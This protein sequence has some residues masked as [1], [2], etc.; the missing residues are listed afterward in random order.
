MIQPR[1]IPLMDLNIP[2]S[3]EQYTAKEYLRSLGYF[4]K[5]VNSLKGEITKTYRICIP[6]NR[7]SASIRQKDSPYIGEL[8]KDKRFCYGS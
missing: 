4:F 2:L 5:E 3:P 7:I 1:Q 8:L 6:R